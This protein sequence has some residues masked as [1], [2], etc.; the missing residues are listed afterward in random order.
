MSKK[1]FITILVILVGLILLSKI[2]FLIT[3]ATKIIL[4]GAVVATLVLIFR[5]KLNR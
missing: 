5:K 2:S 3:I 4:L 1:I